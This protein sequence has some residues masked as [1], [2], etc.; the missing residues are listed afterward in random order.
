ME[1]PLKSRR[2]RLRI[3]LNDRRLAREGNRYTRLFAGRRLT[4]PDE[5]AI[6]RGVAMDFPHLEAKPKGRLRILTVHHHYNWEN[7]AF[8][9]A[10][11]PFGTVHHYDWMTSFRRGLTQWHR[12]LAGEM[13]RDLLRQVR[14]LAAGN[15]IDVIF[16]YL[17]GEQVHPETMAALQA[18]R[19]PMVNLALNDK[20]NFTGKIRS[21]RAMGIRDICRFFTLCWTSTEDALPKYCV[22]KARPLYLPEGA[23]PDLHKPVPAEQTIDVSFIGQC[24]GNREDMIRKLQA[25]GIRAEAY[26][27][28]WPNGPLA[29]EAMVALYSKSRINLGFGGVISHTGAYCLKGRDFEVPMSGGLYLTEHHPELAKVYDIGREIVTYEGFEDL[30][31]KIRDLL[32]HPDQAREIRRRGFERARRE[33]SW[34]MRFD[35]VFRLLGLIA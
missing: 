21:G 12:S 5:G 16:T 13:N 6:R 26:G 1:D 32:D 14:S 8:L 4:I 35:K 29:T 7:T 33:H 3:W 19:I 22:E 34:E 25:E 18:L 10:L 24:Y 28:G 31:G 17:S 23:N 9:P 2:Q 30:L 15:G 20:E 11:E 27:F